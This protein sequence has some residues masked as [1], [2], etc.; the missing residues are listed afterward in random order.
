MKC[1]YCYGD[2]GCHPVPQS[3][4]VH[5]RNL[6]TVDDWREVYQFMRY[7]YL[8]FMHRIA[9]RAEDR[10]GASHIVPIHMKRSNR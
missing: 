1:D 2:D 3:P 7:I 10:A 9:Q 6:F 5:A 4:D 8:P